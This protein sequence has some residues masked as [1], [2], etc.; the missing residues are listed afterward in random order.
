LLHQI[1]PFMV[2][3]LELLNP[4]PHSFSLYRCLSAST[5]SNPT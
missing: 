2:H 3:P 1:T 5:F 4:G